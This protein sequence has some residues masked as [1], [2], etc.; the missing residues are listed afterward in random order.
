MSNYVKDLMGIVKA[1]H[2]AE[3]EFHQAVVEVAESLEVCF[4]RHP[5]YRICKN[6]RTHH[7]T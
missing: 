6:I 1:K 2:P 4:D 3:P 5:E 7:R